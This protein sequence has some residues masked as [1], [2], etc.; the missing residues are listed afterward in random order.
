[1]AT[2]TENRMIGSFYP[3]FSVDLSDMN[4]ARK[5]I[6]K[7]EDRNGAHVVSFCD[8]QDMEKKGSLSQL[9]SLTDLLEKLFYVSLLEPEKCITKI[10]AESR[11]GVLKK[12]QEEESKVQESQLKFHLDRFF[13]PKKRADVSQDDKDIQKLVERLIVGLGGDPTCRLR[14]EADYVVYFD[15]NALEK[16]ALVR[17]LEKSVSYQFITECFFHMRWLE[18]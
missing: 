15:K 18:P 8:W 4:Q 14:F 5:H 11:K 13:H 16:E 1:M 12:Q 6:Q 9:Y 17:D 10:L 3:N 2:E 7:T